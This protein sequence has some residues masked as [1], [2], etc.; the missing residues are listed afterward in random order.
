MTPTNRQPKPRNPIERMLDVCD[1]RMSLPRLVAAYHANQT[2]RERLW[3]L[4]YGRREMRSK[5]ERGSEL[6]KS[7]SEAQKVG[8][9]FTS[10]V[11]V[12]RIYRLGFVKAE[13]RREAFLKDHLP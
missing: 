6:Y 7:L 9:L 11:A 2:E 13:S 12:S 3:A 1:S 5:M 8:A 10:E 4:R